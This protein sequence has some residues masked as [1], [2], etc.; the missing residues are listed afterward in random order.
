VG[1]KLNEIYQLLVY[2]V[3][4][5]LQENNIDTMKKNTETLTEASKEDGLE[6]QKESTAY[7]AVS[8]TGCRAKS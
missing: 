2:A 3:H 6:M 8:P 4:V 1:L 5:N 7:V